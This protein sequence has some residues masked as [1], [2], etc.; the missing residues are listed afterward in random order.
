V[1]LRTFGRIDYGTG[2][3]DLILNHASQLDLEGVVSKTIDAPY[4]PGT[5]ACRAKPKH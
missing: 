2:G 3:G 1:I 5:A 4:T